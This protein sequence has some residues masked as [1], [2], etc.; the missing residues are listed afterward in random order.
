MKELQLRNAVKINGM[1]K[2]K[3]SFNNAEHDENKWK[4]GQIRLLPERTAF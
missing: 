1:Q 4:I 2:E 3:Y